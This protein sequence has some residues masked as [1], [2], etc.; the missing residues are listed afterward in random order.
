MPK[1]PN[2]LIRRGTKWCFRKVYPENLRKII[3]RDEYMKSLRTGDYQEAL[4]R[5]PLKLIEAE[6][7]IAAARR[8]LQQLQNQEAVNSAELHIDALSKEEI[9]SI[10]LVWFHDLESSAMPEFEASLRGSDEEIVADALKGDLEALHSA[11]NSAREADMSGDWVETETCKLLEGHHIEIDKDSKQY[12]LVRSLVLRGLTE[13]NERRLKHLTN[14]SYQKDSYFKE[15]E[16]ASPLPEQVKKHTPKAKLTV[17][18]LLKKYLAERKVG[19]YTCGQYTSI[20]N[21][22]AE[23]VGRNTPIDQIQHDDFLKYRTLLESVPS[24]ASK[25]FA[26]MTYREVVKSPKAKELPKKAPRT[27]NK[28]IE[29]LSTLFGYAAARREITWNPANKLQLKIKKNSNER[30]PYS[31]DDLKAVFNAPLYRGCVDDELNYAKKGDCI[32]KRHRFWVPL[33]ALYAGMR[34]NEICQLYVEDIKQD[35]GI[36]YIEIREMREDGSDADDKKLK[37]MSATRSVPIHSELKRLGF[38]EYVDKLRE[39]GVDR[40]FPLL[41]LTKSG[42]LRAVQRWHG[43]FLASINLAGRSLCFHSY[44]H[45]FRDRLR[46]AEVFPDYYNRIC[47]WTES[48]STAKHYGKGASIAKLHEQIEKVNY[49][50]LDLSHLYVDAIK[51]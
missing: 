2:G 27:I 24:N 21:H 38:I 46:E 8:K 1:R 32:I 26:G 51:D 35:G 5:Y 18:G 4:K 36:D 49:P 28:E 44:R 50:D 47:G 11:S 29:T 42:Y 31:A 14:Q 7:I 12:K 41:K 30:L 6:N 19:D 48:T 16:H 45:T 22:F 17:H 9:Q 37:N 40:V 23:F 43:R 3:E 25:K 10:V 13:S 34:L 20:C 15:I 33:I 39:Q